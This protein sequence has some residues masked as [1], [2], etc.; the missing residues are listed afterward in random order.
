MKPIIMCS[1]LI[2]VTLVA[3]SPDGQPLWE[4]TGV[5]T[6]AGQSSQMDSSAQ[7]M[8]FASRSI[9]PSPTNTPA[10][11]QTRL[12]RP[13]PAP[14]GLPGF[15]RYYQIR[16]YPGCHYGPTPTPAQRPYRSYPAPTGLPGFRRYYQ[17]R[18][19]P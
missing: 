6:T 1:V 17:I 11:T 10:P 19:Y 5:L 7:G 15:R 14:T 12:I 18:C 16:C 4:F 3:C 8:P 9:T 2:L 13:Y